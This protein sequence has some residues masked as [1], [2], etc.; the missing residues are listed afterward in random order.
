MLKWWIINKS[1]MTKYKSQINVWKTK[2]TSAKQINNNKL[3]RLVATPQLSQFWIEQILCFIHFYKFSTQLVFI[4]NTHGG[5]PQLSLHQ[6]ILR[7]I[8]KKP[9]TKL[10]TSTSLH[11]TLLQNSWV[12]SLLCID[13]SLDP[14]Y[15]YFLISLLLTKLLDC[16]VVSLVSK[17]LKFAFSHLILLAILAEFPRN[18]HQK[19]SQQSL[20]HTTTPKNTKN[21]TK[22]PQKQHFN[23]SK[24]SFDTN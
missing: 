10:W 1:V 20:M 22:T 17:V 23:I 24:S 7:C 8:S 19:I 15:C 5:G 21:I 11:S 4:I 18:N 2:F 12:D 14:H 13:L 3:K 16:L 9:K 6:K